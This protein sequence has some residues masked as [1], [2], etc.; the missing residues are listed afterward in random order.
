MLFGGVLYFQTFHLV[1]VISKRTLS[2]ESKE[3]RIDWEWRSTGGGIGVGD[4]V[5]KDTEG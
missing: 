5:E 3:R 2:N 1:C 4:S